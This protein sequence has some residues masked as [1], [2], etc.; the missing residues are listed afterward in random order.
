MKTRFL[1]LIPAL[2]VLGCN[3]KKEDKLP[4]PAVCNIQQTYT[5]NEAKVTISQGI[6]GTI[7]SIEG[8]CM[9]AIGPGPSPCSHC[10]VKRTV[11]IYEYTL[12]SNAVQ[13]TQPGFYISFNTQLIREVTTDNDGFFQTDLPPGQYS[14]VI[15]ENGQLYGNGT[16]GVGG[17]N[18]L[19]Y[20]SGLINLNLKMTYKAVF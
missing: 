6:W 20:T 7:S 13:G 19:N 14:I 9:P 15:V 5:Q 18:P 3:N 17:I 10:P 4:P 11:R 8:N 2:S 1:L 12:R 16:D